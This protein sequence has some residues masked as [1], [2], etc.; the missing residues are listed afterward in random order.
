MIDSADAEVRIAGSVPM[1]ETPVWA[2]LERRLFDVLDGAWREFEATYCEPDGR[3]TYAGRMH[4]RDGV[5]DFYEP[6]FNWPV[7]FRLGGSDDLLPA[8]KRHW[9]GVT[10][11]MT[12][13]GFVKDEYELGYDW[14]HQ[15]ESMIFFYAICAADPTDAD[16]SA[17]AKKFA[18]L[19]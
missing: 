10:T 19:Y 1:R 9:E 14:F 8:A 13:F 15:G 2:V 4:H 12:E 11:Q 7:L 17:R 6:F 16:F 5:D 3:L 18:R